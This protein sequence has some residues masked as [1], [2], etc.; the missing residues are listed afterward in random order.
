MTN[1]YIIKGKIEIM[2]CGK[3]EEI[4]YRLWQFDR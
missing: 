1:N 4:L 3:K 2:K